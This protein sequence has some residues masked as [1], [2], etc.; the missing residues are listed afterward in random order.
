L[1]EGGDV[2][3]GGHGDIRRPNI[4]ALTWLPRHDGV[5][6]SNRWKHITT[7]AEA[8]AAILTAK[9]MIGKVR[10]IPRRPKKGGNRRLGTA[11]LSSITTAVIDAVYEKLV[12]VTEVTAAGDVIERERR[13][14]INHAMKSCRRAWNIAARR[15]PGKVPP[16]NPFAQMGLESSDRKTPTA[17][18]AELRAFRAKGIERRLPSPV[19]AFTA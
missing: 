6:P 11:R 7:D 18:F 9:H 10:M 13:T 5:A 15:N 12:V 8:R 19:T 2:P 1:S 17:T 3:G 16:I 4:W 14:S